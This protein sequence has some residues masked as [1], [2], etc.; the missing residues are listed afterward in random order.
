MAMLVTYDS[1]ADALYIYVQR[2]VA[3]A[4]SVL[5]DD[6]RVVDLDETGQVVGIEVISPSTGFELEDIVERFHLERIKQELHHAAQ[7]FRP[8]ASA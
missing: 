6:S 4:R 1:S 3:V 8:A 2:G 7:E 5:I